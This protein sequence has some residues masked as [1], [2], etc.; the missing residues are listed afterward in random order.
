MAMDQTCGASDIEQE[1]SE[2]LEGQ[3]TLPTAALVAGIVS[4]SATSSSRG[5]STGTGS[6]FVELDSE[7][8]QSAV[9]FLLQWLRSL[10]PSE[11]A[12]KGKVT[13]NLPIGVKRGKIGHASTG[14]KNVSAAD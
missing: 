9:V 11:L 7:S 6:N 3:P 13:T 12:Q 8:N 4:T 10:T 5:F 14:L 1:I 2:S